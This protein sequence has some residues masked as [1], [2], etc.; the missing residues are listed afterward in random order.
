[1]TRG[2]NW[3]DK[4][5]KNPTLAAKAAR[6]IRE[7]TDPGPKRIALLAG[8]GVAAERGDASPAKA[9]LSEA[10]KVKRH[11]VRKSKGGTT[12]ANARWREFVAEM[13]KSMKQDT[14]N[15][16]LLL[17]FPGLVLLSENK[18]QR[19]NAVRRGSW[20][21]LVTN[22]ATCDARNA[23][24]NGAFIYW[25]FTVPVR[26][27]VW[28]VNRRPRIDPG[29]LYKKALIDTLSER[30]GGVG[31]IVDDGPKYIVSE[32]TGYARGK[33]EGVI[34]IVE[35]ATAPTFDAL[36]ETETGR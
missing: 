27:E 4:A 18:A 1:M 3:N 8:I 17:W 14:P 31:I 26:I 5:R 10:P 36:L 12:K 2:A 16:R 30:A 23:W 29:N 9:N 32:S 7:A 25:R 19:A 34:V 6:G 21:N 13:R 33:T 35:P 11:Q 22:R 28:Q 15:Q 20:A 24:M